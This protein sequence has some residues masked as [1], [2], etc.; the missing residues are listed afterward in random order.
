MKKIKSIVLL[1]IS[2]L[3]YLSVNSQ[4]VIALEHQ[5]VSAF[6]Q[7]LDSAL[8]HSV[9]GDNIVLPGASYN[10][11]AMNIDKGVHIIGAGCNF[12]STLATNATVFL[13]T[14]RINSGSDKGSLEGIYINGDLY[15]GTNAGNQEIHNYSVRRCYMNNLY[16]SFDGVSQTA[17]SN[18]FISEN[19]IKGNIS[20]GNAQ[21]VEVS[22]CIIDNTIN[23][24]NGNAVFSNNV[25]LR[26][27][28]G[29]YVL[30]G[31]NAVTFQNNI[32][33]LTYCGYWGSFFLIGTGTG[34]SFIN[35]SFI[36]DN[37]IPSGN[38]NNGN[39]FKVHPDTLFINQSGNT[40]NIKHNYHLKP[41]CKGKNAGTDGTD[42]GI[43][44][45]VSPA[46]E[47][48]I[49]FN[50]HLQTKSIPSSTNAEGNLN[51][52]IK[53]KAQEN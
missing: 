20:G 36:C 27:A 35:N 16:L 51:I 9:N 32:S 52:N 33:L 13:G 48:Q 4:N 40:Y 42:A 6:Y 25:L 5:G 34:N 46:K 30:N 22:K 26:N 19:I 28:C 38:I 10:I 37:P 41:S 1:I 29:D 49:P 2:S 31:V 12:D 44:G 43:Y 15:F 53:V 47:G 8:A 45:T 3:M 39:I 17:S 21:N 24:F 11:G 50:P 14:L 7:S 23:N 18:L